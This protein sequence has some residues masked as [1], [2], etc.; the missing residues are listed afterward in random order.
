[1]TGSLQQVVST[2]INMVST[3]DGSQRSYLFWEIIYR[4][5]FFVDM[6]KPFAKA[7]PGYCSVKC[8]TTNLA[9]KNMHSSY[10][11]TKTNL[12]LLSLRLECKQQISEWFANKHF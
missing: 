8:F 12:R 3:N 5:S 9:A 2:K 4:C 6:K 7:H 11:I 1:M 10:N